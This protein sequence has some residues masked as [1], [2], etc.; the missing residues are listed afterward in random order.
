MRIADLHRS[1]AQAK[2]PRQKSN[3]IR[4]SLKDA[5]LAAFSVFFRQCESF[6]EHQ[7]QMQ[8]RRG[9]GLARK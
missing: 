7:R 4:Y 3:E 1:I 2:D 9:K 8:S 6:L 5:I